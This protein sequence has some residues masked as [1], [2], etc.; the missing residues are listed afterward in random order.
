MSLPVLQGERVTLRQINDADL[1]ALVAIMQSPGVREW[2]WEADD[3]E[4][5]R[6]GF[7]EDLDSAFAVEV[8][9]ELAG[10]LGFDEATP[11]SR[12]A[13]DTVRNGV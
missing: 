11:C 5:M 7:R 13:S 12:A 1:D 4:R 10:W 9:G 6:D 2:W 8:D 3:A